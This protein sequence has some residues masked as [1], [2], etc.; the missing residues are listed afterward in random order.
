[1]AKVT[2][3]KRASSGFS[4]ASWTAMNTP[5]EDRSVNA[6][7]IE[8]GASR[9]SSRGW[10][11]PSADAAR[12]RLGV[13]SNS[14]AQSICG[15]K[16][17]RPSGDHTGVLRPPSPNGIMSD[18]SVSYTHTSSEPRKSS[19]PTAIRRPSGDR[20]GRISEKVPSQSGRTT[21]PRSSTITARDPGP[22]ST[23]ARV[24]SCAI[25]AVRILPA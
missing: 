9:K 17:S 20:R 25:D 11:P 2:T 10:V 15:T 8:G 3:S 19:T 24:P 6:L 5:S 1:M 14:S 12:I 7:R 13:V 22:A 4:P 18:V 23:I 16:T 21:S